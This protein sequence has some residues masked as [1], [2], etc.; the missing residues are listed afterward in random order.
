MHAHRSHARRVLADRHGPHRRTRADERAARRADAEARPRPRRPRAA[1]H[2]APDPRRRCSPCSSCSALLNVFGQRPATSTASGP[3]AELEALLAEAR[4][5]RARCSSRASTSRRRAE[6]RDATLVL[7]PGWLE[8]MTL[9]TVEPS[10]DRRVEPRRADRVRARPHPGRRRLPA[11]PAVPGEPDERRPPR[12]RRRPLRRRP[13]AAP[14]RPHDHGLALMDIVLRA[15]VAFLFVLLLTRVVGRRELSSLEPFDLILLVMIGDLVQQGVT[16]ND[17]SVTGLFLAGTTIA[18]LTVAI[19]YTSFKLPF[20]RP[21]LDG[22][23]VIVVEDGKPID[24]EPRRATGSRSRSS[25]RPRGSR[26]SPRST[27]CAGPCS[28]RA[29]RSASSRR[30]DRA[31]AA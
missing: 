17:Y 11:L 2:G 1:A 12:D 28:R 26:A 23:P 16:Q 8:G 3:A 9:N 21:V 7:D 27:R 25:R 15:A 18:L 30:A 20:V 10:P 22:E 29:A 5:R 14:R 13:A 6:L 19:S 24:A 4:A 31:G